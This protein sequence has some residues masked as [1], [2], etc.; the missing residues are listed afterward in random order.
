VEKN[1]EDVEQVLTIRQSQK[2]DALKLAEVIYNIF[3]D[4]LSNDTIEK[5]SRKD[6]LDD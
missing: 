5:N 1:I 3:K 4:S 6:N 2:K